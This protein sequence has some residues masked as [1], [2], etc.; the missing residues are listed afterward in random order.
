MLLM[1]I[2]VTW[3]CWITRRKGKAVGLTLATYLETYISWHTYCLSESTGVFFSFL[4][5]LIFD[6]WGLGP[7]PYMDQKPSGQSREDFNSQGCL[8][9][10]TLIAWVN[11]WGCF[12]F[13]FFQDFDFWVL[14]NWSWTLNG[15]KTFGAL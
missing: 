3:I 15:L 8:K 14:A 13:S 12:F 2:H 10:G 1:L 11:L 5:N 9:F 6:P 7:V 4:K